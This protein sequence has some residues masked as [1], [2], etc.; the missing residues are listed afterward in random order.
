R[1]S[2]PFSSTLPRMHSSRYTGSSPRATGC[3][4]DKMSRRN[5]TRLPAQL[6]LKGE[7]AMPFDLSKYSRFLEE[8]ARD[9]D[10]P[11]SKYRDAVDH[12]NA[13][14]RWLD[15]G[16]YP[17]CNGPLTIYVQGSF[18]LG[19]VVRPI[20]NGIEGSYDLDLVSEFP[21]QM[22]QVTPADLKA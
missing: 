19:T 11:P 1:L 3:R 8:V 18:R 20:R 13:V 6:E 4:P 10:I 12:Y 17:G 2:K 9:L 15:Q 14:G 16:R 5:G 22:R 7:Q 21:L